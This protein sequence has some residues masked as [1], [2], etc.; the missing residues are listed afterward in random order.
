M[1]VSHALTVIGWQ[2]NLL[3]E[4]MPPEW[5]WPLTDELEEWFEAVSARRK[6]GTSRDDDLEDAPDMMQNT[7]T[8]GRR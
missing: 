2:E 4:E 6:D 7:L 1:A 8:R 3:S 5:M